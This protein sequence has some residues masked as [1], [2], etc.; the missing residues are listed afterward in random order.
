MNKEIYN[1]NNKEGAYEAVVI[2]VS[3]G[4]MRAL[5]KIIP[6]L[7]G[8]FKV[9]I[10]IIQHRH[11]HSD[12]Y[13]IRFLDK[14]SALTVKEAEEKESITRGVVYFAPS[15]HHLLIEED[16]TFSLC[17]GELVWYARPSIDVTFEIASEIYGMKL[18]GIILTGANSDGSNGMKCIK[19]KG[20]LTIIQDPATAEF[21]NMPQAAL[22]AT[23]IDYIVDLD[24]LITL[25]I[26]LI[27][28]P[29]H[30]GE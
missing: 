7:P 28:S 25:L 1:N 18:I 9:P 2:G 3:A 11:S 30:G 17:S 13:E 21:P 24:N 8:N 5:E 20:G 10:V 26:R 6:S 23:D 16:K 14:I 19:N 27:M 12:N 22:D 15:D 4:G 29:I